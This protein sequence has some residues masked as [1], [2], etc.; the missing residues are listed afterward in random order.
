MTTETAPA[1][2]PWDP[3]PEWNKPS[4]VY[5]AADRLQATLFLRPSTPID[6]FDRPHPDAVAGYRV[7]GAH[8]GDLTVQ[9]T[10][11]DGDAGIV[12]TTANLM[13]ALTV[14]HTA[15]VERLAAGPVR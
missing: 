11:T 6:T 7:V 10:A 15:A 8:I 14:L 9:F 12:A 2:Y 4:A 1:T 5:Q 3:N 13:D